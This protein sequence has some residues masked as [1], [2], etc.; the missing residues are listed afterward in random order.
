MQIAIYDTDLTDGQWTVLRPM[1]PQAGKLGRPATD[2][3]R[4]IDA[5]LYIAKGGISWRLLPKSFPPWQTVYHVFRKWTKDHA[6]EALNARLRALVRKANGKR[7]RPTAAILDSQSVKSDPHGGPVGYDTAK[8]IKGRKRHL[9]VD[10]LGLVLGVLVTPAN[11][12]ERDGAKTLLGL[13]LGWFTWLRLL[14]VD[15]GY[16]GAPFA[17]WVRTQRRKLQVQ[18]VKRSDATAGFKL[19]PRRWVVERTFGWLMRHRRLVRDYETTE[20]SAESW[21]YIAMIR[22]QLRRLA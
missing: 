3:R 21:V 10:T 12:T 18:V 19:L 13:V 17:Q 7:A 4:I 16:T 9:L 2:R 20:T 8:K 15:A 11:V 6:W 1:L 5:L 22:L 14:W